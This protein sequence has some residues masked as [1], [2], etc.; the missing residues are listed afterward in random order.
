MMAGRLSCESVEGEGAEFRIDL[1]LSTA[2]NQDLLVQQP[3]APSDP[4]TV[5]LK[6][7]QQSR[8]LYVEDN[9]SNIR[10]MQQ[11]FSRYP[12]LEL[13]VAEEA[14]LGIYK[15]RNEQRDVV[16]QIGRA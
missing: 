7:S 16:I 4:K 15:A 2:W 13:E 8:I 1:P 5:E 3:P 11:L 14:L 12:E 10:L 6:V 9:P